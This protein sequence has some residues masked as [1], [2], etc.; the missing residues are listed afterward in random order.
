MY[1]NISLALLAA[2]SALTVAGAMSPAS[3]EPIQDSYCLQ[4]RSHG[5]PGDCAYSSYQ[6]CAATASGTL[7][8][9]M[10]AS[11]PGLTWVAPR[12]QRKKPRPEATMPR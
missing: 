11:V 1:R 7:A 6:Q 2:V 4:G 8:L 5:Y 10:A 12:F 9:F 3:A